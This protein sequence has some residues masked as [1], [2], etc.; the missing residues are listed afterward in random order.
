M[1]RKNKGQSQRR[2]IKR[3]HIRVLYNH[4]TNFLELYRRTT[5]S[6]KHTVFIGQYDIS[7]E[8]RAMDEAFGNL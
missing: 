5:T 1:K 7:G 2:A 8:M 6:K 3:G 4:L